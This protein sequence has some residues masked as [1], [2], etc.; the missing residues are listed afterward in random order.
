MKDQTQS[1]SSETRDSVPADSVLAEVRQL[2]QLLEAKA[3]RPYTDVNGYAKRLGMSP[4]SV[5][6]WLT[7]GLPHIYCGR[8]VRIPV[9]AA[10]AWLAARG[11]QTG[12]RKAEPE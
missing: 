9:Q 5:R 11:K 2:R 10:D 8:S 7:L 1:V 4:R 6:T 3:E 12:D